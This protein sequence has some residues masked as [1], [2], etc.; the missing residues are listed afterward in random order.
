LLRAIRLAAQL[1]FEIEPQTF[2]AIQTRAAQI[3]GISAERI[4]EELIKLFQAPHASRGLELLSQSGLLAHILPEIQATSTCEQS[5]DYHPEGTV[6]N[7]LR[8]M[9]EHLPT[10][11]L[12]ALPWAVL[13]HD[14]AKPVTASRDPVS[15]SI[16]FYGHERVGAEM[17][18]AA[19]KRLRFPRKQ[20]EAIVKAVRYHMQFKDA[21]QMRKST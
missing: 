14:V 5:P 12:P 8:L 18:E 6:F 17:A 19:L 11:S 15:G 9:L 3:R 7:H 16:H 2:A 1:N 20:I 10:D 13:F 4:R 21:P